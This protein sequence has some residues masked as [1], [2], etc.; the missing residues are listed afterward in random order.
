MCSAGAFGLALVSVLWAYDGWADVSYVAGEVTEPRKN[1]PRA[2]IGGTL[3]VMAIYVLANI[4]Y[5]AVLPIEEIRTS[6]LVAADVAEKLM[7]R[8]GRRHSCRRP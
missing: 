2:I 5:M 6:R 7:G 8:A 1:L 3:A 4:G